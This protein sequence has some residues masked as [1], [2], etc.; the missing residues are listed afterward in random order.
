[1][2]QRIRFNKSG[3]EVE[4]QEGGK[5]VETFTIIWEVLRE[6]VNPEVREYLR[7]AWNPLNLRMRIPSL[8]FEFPM[9]EAE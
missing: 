8:V 2:L 3:M 1:M 4:N 7:L 5:I 6:A 9:S